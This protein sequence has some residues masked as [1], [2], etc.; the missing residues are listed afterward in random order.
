GEEEAEDCDPGPLLTS[1]A[2][3]LR[4]S[5]R[6]RPLEL[7]VEVDADVPDALRGDPARVRQIVLNLASNAVK[8]T[9]SGHARFRA[10]IG[11]ERVLITVS[12]TGRGIGEQD[13]QRLF[14]PWTRNHTRA[15]AGTGLGLSIARR[16][17][18]AM[19]GDVTVV[20]DPGSR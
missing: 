8:Y 17:A 16:L 2:G 1:I 11:G 6:G 20:S 10:C 4:P 19:G 5:L 9:E 7:L 18:R 14:E 12:D 3:I 13:L 15:W